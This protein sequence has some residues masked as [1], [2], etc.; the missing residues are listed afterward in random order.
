MEKLKIKADAR[1]VGKKGVN[2]RLRKDGFI[3]AVLY[4]HGENPLALSVNSKEFTTKIKAL[5]LNVLI[6]LDVPGGS[7]NPHVV[8]L[9]DY[10]TDSLK[11]KITHIDLL[12]IN[13]KEKVTVKIPLK[14]VGK[15][16]GLAKGGLVEQARR[17]LEVHCLPSN[18]PDVIEVDITEL[19]VGSSL[20]MNQIKLPHGVEAPHDVDFAIVSIVV[21]REE[22]VE[23]PA[24]AAPVEGAVAAG[25]GATTAAAPAEGEKKAEG[26]KKPGEKK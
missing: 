23:E 17:E 6:E 26:D 1:E 3:P 24:A 13:L 2:R 21:P 25:A 22:V 4:G 10:Q 11:R 8:M 15:A 14:I 9:K 12:K 7:Q 19:D 18:I 16:I 5:G 20:H